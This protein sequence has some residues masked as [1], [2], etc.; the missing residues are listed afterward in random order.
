MNH[1]QEPQVAALE[2]SQPTDPDSRNESRATG[3]VRHYQIKWTCEG[4]WDSAPACL[5]SAASFNIKYS[6]FAE[7]ESTTSTGCSLSAVPSTAK[8]P[9]I[10]L[11]M[12]RRI[13]CTYQIAAFSA[14]MLIS[15]SRANCYDNLSTDASQQQTQFCKGAMKPRLYYP[16]D[17]VWRAILMNEPWEKA[18]FAAASTN[19]VESA[20]GIRFV[21]DKTMLSRG[22]TWKPLVSLQAISN[23]T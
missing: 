2:R 10:Y 8:L 11:Q 3:A 16:G 14:T 22:E 5:M 4:R 12:I 18:G 15:K 21:L 13:E 23:C 1:E 7:Y 19:T 20:L 17:A 6:C 9:H